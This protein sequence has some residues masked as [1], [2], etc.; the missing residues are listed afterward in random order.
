MAPLGM[1][2]QGEAGQFRRGLV[3]YG[4]V[5]CGLVR[6]GKAGWV[7]RGDVRQGEDRSGE[8]GSAWLRFA[9]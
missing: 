3:G 9:R 7:G 8:A 1:V 2:S 5:E 4:A 6:R